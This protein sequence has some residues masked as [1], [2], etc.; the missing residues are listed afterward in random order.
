MTREAGRAALAA[1]ESVYRE[2]ASEQAWVEELRQ[3]VQG[4]LPSAALAV[5]TFLFSPAGEFRPRSYA[6]PDIDSFARTIALASTSTLRRVFARGPVVK[7]T[8]RIAPNDPSWVAVLD[9]GYREIVG[10]VCRDTSNLGAFIAFHQT[11]ELTLTPLERRRLSRVSAHVATA[12]RLRSRQRKTEAVLGGDGKLLDASG[13]ARRSEQREALQRAARALDR[14]WARASYEPEACLAVWHA[15]IDGRWTLHERFESDGRRFWVALEN[16]P[17]DAQAHKLTE[18][19]SAV[20]GLVAVGHAQKLVAYEL[21][22]SEAL[23]S[24]SIKSA[25][26][27]LGARSRAELVALYAALTEASATPK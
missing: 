9:E 3:A 21:G 13:P 11:R 26:H 20:V 4:V 16:A 5:G 7:V 25:L 22:L 24:N 19:E 6:G 17:T 27:K 23:I 14:A 1:A 12:L 18:R 15:L 8:E 10:C 2:H